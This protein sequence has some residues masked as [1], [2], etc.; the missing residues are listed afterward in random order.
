MA[1][2]RWM[3]ADE[4]GRNA[5]F[6]SPTIQRNRLL[7]AFPHMSS[8]DGLEFRDLAVGAN[9]AHFDR[10][11]MNHLNMNV[12]RTV[13]LNG[14]RSLQLRVDALNIFNNETYGQHDPAYVRRAG[15]AFWTRQ[16]LESSSPC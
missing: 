6:T 12:A 8:G 4:M 3:M 13:R 1:N 9:R 2:G 10:N 5:F 11:Q 16:F 7:R 14:N 15:P